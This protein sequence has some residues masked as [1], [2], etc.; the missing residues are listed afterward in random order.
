MTEQTEANTTVY[1]GHGVRVEHH[2]AFGI[3]VWE[4]QAPGMWVLVRTSICPYTA[5]RI[6]ITT[7]DADGLLADP[8]ETARLT[9]SWPPVGGHRT[10]IERNH[11][12]DTER[13]K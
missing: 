9:R 5:A 2:P 8:A 11:Y 4:E 12:A 10:K 6:A 1:D 7:L 13:T 3:R